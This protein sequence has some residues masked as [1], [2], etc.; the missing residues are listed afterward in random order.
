MYELN[1]HHIWALAHRGVV[2]F[3]VVAVT[4]T[5]MLKLSIEY[6]A[7][8]HGI[9]ICFSFVVAVAFF[10]LFNQYCTWVCIF[11][12]FSRYSPCEYKICNRIE[13]FVWFASFPLNTQIWKPTVLYIGEEI[14]E[15]KQKLCK[16]SCCQPKN[17]SG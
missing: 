4:W 3:G 12:Y 8:K 16:F 9:S 14:F 2:W 15:T 6:H 13:V 1:S 17:K 10:M 5:I 7:W 11:E